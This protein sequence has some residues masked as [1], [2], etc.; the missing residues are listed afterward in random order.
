MLILGWLTRLAHA[1]S[2]RSRSRPRRRR[3]LF[4]AKAERF[5][6]RA[7]LSA[8]FVTT[9]ID[10]TDVLLGD[11]LAQT[12]D[13]ET[14]LRSAV[15]EANAQAG[16]DSI[17]LPDGL[18][19]LN[20]LENPLSDASGGDLDVTD[21]LT[22][23]GAGPDNTVIDA[24]RIDRMFE[25]FGRASLEL[26]DLT[27]QVRDINHVIYISDGLAP[28]TNVAIVEVPDLASS[29][30]VSPVGP[31]PGSEPLGPGVLN[32]ADEADE[33]D[34]IEF[35]I[36]TESEF[37]DD[38]E[39][40]IPIRQYEP[41]S[42]NARQ[43]ELVQILSQVDRLRNDFW[44]SHAAWRVT[45]ESSRPDATLGISSESAGDLVELPDSPPRIAN[46]DPDTP[47]IDA[48]QPMPNS[49]ISGE[50]DSK[51]NPNDTP[52]KR[53][54]D[55]VNSLFENGRNDKARVNPVGAEAVPSPS[56]D[57]DDRKSI[58]PL[59]LP[60][61]DGPSPELK[62]NALFPLNQTDRPAPPPLPTSR[63]QAQANSDSN[64]GR[65]ATSAV[66]AGVLFAFVRPRESRR[67]N[68]KPTQ[69]R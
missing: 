4:M 35:E 43:L 40:A 53:R 58:P 39:L 27:I 19:A 3:S 30:V 44:Q 47:S 48:R 67:A 36:E 22:I 2:G 42:N 57:I 62:P 52:A 55:V 5:E 34:E 38:A 15:E 41:L 11:G 23:R 33:V 54:D 63:D 14:S 49:G 20:L 60:E 28:F 25:L 37:D 32:V 13:G 6:T 69:P 31:T 9:P 16:A 17:Q 1:F 45:A 29:D 24:T 46:N 59:L 10:A 65:S 51:T 8:F 21:S 18:F 66:A 64:P 26:H 61:I 7:M 50:T 12:S 56:D 68:K